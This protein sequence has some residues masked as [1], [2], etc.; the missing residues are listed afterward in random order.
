[1]RPHGTRDATDRTAPPAMVTGGCRACGVGD[2][3]PLLD[4]GPQPPSNRFVTAQDGHDD[5]H[6]LVLGQ[7]QRCGLLQLVNPMPPAMVRPRYGWLTYNEPEGHLDTLVAQLR[8]FL[9]DGDRASLLGVTYKDDTTLTRFRAAGYDRVRRLDPA[10]AGVQTPHAGI[11][12]LQAALTARLGAELA[13]REGPADLVVARHVLEHAHRPHQLMEC[14]VELT[15]PGGLLAVE[16][17][18]AAKFVRTADYCYLWE[19]H[20]AYFSEQ[21]LRAFFGYHGAEVVGVWRY[22]YPAEDSLVAVVRRPVAGRRSDAAGSYPWLETELQS[23]RHFAERFEET[24]RAYGSH[25]SHLHAQ[26]K[27][28]A[29]FGAGHLAVKF[30]NLLDLSAGIVYVIDDNPHKTGLVMPGSR[31]P[32][33]GSAVLYD[34]KIDLCLLSLSP[35]NEARVITRHQAYLDGG[36]V[37]RSVFALSPLA[38]WRDIQGRGGRR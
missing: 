33:V 37:F 10:A 6:P 16:V 27:R 32:I 30:I 18:D 7:C 26:G 21:T 19:E 3:R 11:E 38:L 31:L 28:I 34:D 25:L 14:L 5:R 12:T 15:T 35:E 22:P 17:P 36:G 24:R 23:G 29:V 13:R 4:F 9:P 1:M 8:G 20:I 2:V